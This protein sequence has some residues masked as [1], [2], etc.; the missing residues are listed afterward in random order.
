MTIQSAARRRATGVPNSSDWGCLNFANANGSY[1]V[2]YAVVRY[3][4]YQCSGLIQ[5][6]GSLTLRHV[7]VEK[8]SGTAIYVTGSQTTVADSVIATAG[9]YAIDSRSTTTT[10]Q[11]NTVTNASSGIYANGSVVTVSNNRISQGGGTGIVLANAPNATL[12]GN[13]VTNMGQGLQMSNSS[14]TITNNIVKDNGGYPFYQFD[15]AFPTY[16]GNTVTGNGVQAIAVGGTIGT[17]TWVN[18]QG[19]GLPY[20]VVGSIAVPQGTTLTIPAGTVVKFAFASSRLSLVVSGNLATQ[21]TAASPVVFTS[22]NDNTVG[23]PPTGSGVPNSSDWGCLNFAERQRELSGGVRRGAL[24]RLSVLRLDSEC[25][26]PHPP[27]RAGRESYGD[28]LYATYSGRPLTVEGCTF[29]ANGGSGIR[30]QQ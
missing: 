6:A 12:T 13:T 29:H 18:V 3:G 17:G 15:N 24:R 27:P 14:P 19:L 21:G 4:G 16:S 20:V 30:V 28:G 22:V 25:R 10:L 26:Q 11:N 23:G 9:G 2:E 7:T 5:S 8:A 1:Q